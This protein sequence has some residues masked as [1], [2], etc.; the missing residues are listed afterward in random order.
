MANWWTWTSGVSW[1]HPQGPGSTIK[2][3]DDLP[4][5][6]V[7]WDDAAAYA[8]WAGKRL[9]TEAEWEFASR[10]GATTNTRYW[11]GDQFVPTSGP[12]AGKYMANTYTGEFPVRD[13]GADGFDRTAPVRSF[14]A[15]GYGLYDMAGNVWNWTA[16]LYRADAH[17]ISQQ[18]LTAAGTACCMN[19]TGPTDCFNP[20]R[21]V[22]NTVE[23]VVKGGSFLCNASYCESYRPTARRG[24]PPDTGTEHIGFRCVLSPGSEDLGGDDK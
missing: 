17:A 8:K 14:P 9:P 13:T 4:V 16:D 15:N 20:T 22:S 19:P 6:Q 24:M 11:W 10:G 12:H 3:K 5:I 18:E 1:K 2:G 7:S 21:P 23:R